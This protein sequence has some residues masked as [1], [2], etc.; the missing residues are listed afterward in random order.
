MYIEWVRSP[1]LSHP[2]AYTG[3]TLR[4]HLAYGTACLAGYTNDPLDTLRYPSPGSPTSATPSVRT[5]T[6]SMRRGALPAA[7]K[8]AELLSTWLAEDGEQHEAGPETIAILVRD[9]YQRDAV[10]TGLAERGVEVRAVGREAVERGRPVV[11]TMHRAKGLEFRKVL[12]V[13]VSEASIPRALRDLDYSDA[14]RTDA[15]LRERSLLYVAATRARD[16]LAISWS[17]QASP[18]LEGIAGEG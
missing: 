16:Q 4:A 8:A 3:L 14:E 11:M 2:C 13:D 10:A 1:C 18:L 5:R 6:Q 17:G 9:R 7:S 12:L 15:L